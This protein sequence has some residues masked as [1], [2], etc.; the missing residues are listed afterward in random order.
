MRSR[1]NAALSFFTVAACTLLLSSLPTSRAATSYVI[2]PIDPN[3]GATC[4]S[5]GGSWDGSS[6][7]TLGTNFELNPG[8]SLVID[9]AAALAIPTGITLTNNGNITNYGK[10]ANMPG[11][12]LANSGTITAFIANGTIVNDG[13]ISNGVGGSIDIEHPAQ[14]SPRVG[15]F[16]FTNSGVLDNLGTIVNFGNFTNSA[17]ASVTNSGTFS[18]ES[19]TINVGKFSAPVTFNVGNFTN[20][21]GGTVNVSGAT[22]NNTG[23]M[24]NAGTI[25]EQQNVFSR[26]NNLGTLTSN[27]TITNYGYVVNVEGTII[28]SGTI[29]NI[30]GCTVV[31]CGTIANTGI[32]INEYGGNISNQG[33]FGNYNTNPRKPQLGSL[34]N[35]GT[36]TNSNLFVNTLGSTTTNSGEINNTGTL[37]NMGLIGNSGSI[38]SSGLILNSGYIGN[39]S[40]GTITN[41]RTISN[42]GTIANLGAL[43]DACGGVIDPTGTI[44]GNQVAGATTCTSTAAPVP[45]FPAEMVVPL[46]L[47]MLALVSL[48]HRKVPWHRAHPS[49]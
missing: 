45:E 22:I 35:N 43:A 46:L 11:G 10:I 6:T 1:S 36:L 18:I 44:T 17:E 26:I 4:A 38:S 8:D 7:C 25:A 34:L 14:A 15:S 9:P 21:V 31:S 47:S 12:I 23:L 40:S 24:T 41:S 42:T 48:V 13:S 32:V 37:S 2:S 27:G 29:S 28:N 5:L 20:A 16:N 30:G 39:N 19:A 3:V 33:N 49:A